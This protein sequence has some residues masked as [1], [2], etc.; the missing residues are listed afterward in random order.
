MFYIMIP[1]GYAIAGWIGVLSMAIAS[2]VERMEIN[3]VDDNILI[4]L[5]VTVVL[6]LWYLIQIV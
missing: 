2:V 3:P 1:I 4:T 6:A 5:S